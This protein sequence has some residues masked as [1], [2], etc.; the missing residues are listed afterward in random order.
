MNPASAHIRADADPTQGRV[1][2]T[3]FGTL[4][5][6]MNPGRLPSCSSCIEGCESFAGIW[7]ACRGRRTRRQPFSSARSSARASDCTRRRGRIHGG[8][9]RLPL[10]DAISMLSRIKF[11]GSTRRLQW[12][13]GR[14]L[15]L[16]GCARLALNS[17]HG[18]VLAGWGGVGVGGYW[19]RI[20]TVAVHHNRKY[21]RSSIPQLCRNLALVQCRR[22][23]RGLTGRQRFRQVGAGSERLKRFLGRRCA[24]TRSRSFRFAEGWAR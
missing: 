9:G 2:K 1:L 24:S 19:Q 21:V 14:E 5:P 6:G 16:A 8:A 10:H 23:G 7:L 17:G 3:C 11:A 18:R 12:I 13:G 15:F 20:Q 4:R 22:L